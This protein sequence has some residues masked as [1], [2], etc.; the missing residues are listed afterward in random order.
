[1]YRRIPEGNISL[2]AGEYHC[3]AISLP[4]S[5]NITVALGDHSLSPSATF[6][7]CIPTRFVI[8]L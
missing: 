2:A 1:M 3:E 5:G 6:P 7:S 4:R 8:Y